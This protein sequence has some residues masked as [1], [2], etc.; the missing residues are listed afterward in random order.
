MPTT[1]KYWA[2]GSWAFVLGYAVAY[3]FNCG[4]A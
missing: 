4:G 1:V 2:V 3:G